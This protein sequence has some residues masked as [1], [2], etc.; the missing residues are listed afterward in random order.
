M[1]TILKCLDVRLLLVLPSVPLRGEK[2]WHLQVQALSGFSFQL[3]KFWDNPF[4]VN[5]DTFLFWHFTALTLS[6]SKKILILSDSDT[7]RILK[8]LSDS[9]TFKGFWHSLILTHSFLTYPNYDT[10]QL[11]E[12]LTYFDSAT[13]RFWNIFASL[14]FDTFQFQTILALSGSDTFRIEP[15]LAKIEILTHSD[16]DTFSPHFGR[17]NF[18]KVNRRVCFCFYNKER[19]RGFL[20]HLADMK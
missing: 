5:S 14:D 15:K 17:T 20:F 1:S 2:F 16:S 4:L 13:F 10:F 18:P 6:C 3:K 12:I 8:A 9:D 11:Y 7:F 19:Q